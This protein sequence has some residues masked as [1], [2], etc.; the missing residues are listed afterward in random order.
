VKPG[1]AANRDPKVT[2]IRKAATAATE[3][4][5]IGGRLKKKPPAKPSLPR[6]KCLE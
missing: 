6:L 1:K 5:G 2:L 3:R 4:Y